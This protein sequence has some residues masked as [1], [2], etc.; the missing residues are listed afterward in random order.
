MES[1]REDTWRKR[2]G[3]ISG[4]EKGEVVKKSVMVLVIVTSPGR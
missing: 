1:R 4:I 3:E 2:D